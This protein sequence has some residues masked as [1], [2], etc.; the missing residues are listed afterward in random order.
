M[1]QLETV[2]RHGASLVFQWCQ[3]QIVKEKPSEVPMADD[4]TLHAV[5]LPLTKGL[6]DILKQHPVHRQHYLLF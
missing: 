6:L 1:Q 2:K 4:E 5:C 3:H